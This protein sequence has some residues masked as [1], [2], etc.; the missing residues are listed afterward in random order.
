MG[1]G[2]GPTLSGGLGPAE[3]LEA[4]L[5]YFWARVL[6]K[7]QIGLNENF[8]EA[9]GTSLKAVQLLALI[10]REFK[11]SLP[12]TSL[13]ECPSIGLF[14]ARMKAPAHAR[15]TNAVAALRRG[16]QRRYGKRTRKAA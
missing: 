12:I 16:Q 9:G 8:F 3:T 11:R 1:R 5:A 14:A 6:G 10:Q 7:S 4:T 15:K 13:F 2:K